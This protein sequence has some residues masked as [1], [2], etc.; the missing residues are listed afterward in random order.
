MRIA[1]EDPAA[2]DIVTL[3]EAHLRDMRDTSPPESI[4]ALD[5]DALRSPHITFL[6]ARDDD[7]A[8]WGVGALAELDPSHGE[9]KSMRTTPEAR[10]QGVA[11]AVLTRLIEIASERGYGAVSLETGAEDFFLAAHRLYERHGFVACGPFGT[12]GPDPH[13][14]FY[15]LALPLRAAD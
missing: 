14:R 12:Y 13:S 1:Q 3:L 9:V 5:V 15:T 4:H 7:G 10:G 2:P 11:S 6:A 8:L